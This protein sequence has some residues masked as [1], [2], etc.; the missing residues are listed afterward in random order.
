[1]DGYIAKPVTSN[2]IEAMIANILSKQRK[3]LG[4]PAQSAVVPSVIWDPLKA[5]EKMEGDEALLRE[6]IQIFLEE[7]PKQLDRLNE[8]IEGSDRDS[9]ERTAHSLK[10]E[11]KYL[12]LFDA[13]QQACEFERMGREGDW[14]LANERFRSFRS[15][16]R[17]VT[18]AMHRILQAPET[19][20]LQN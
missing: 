5:L 18:A 6:L 8:A 10:G 17:A 19:S 14:Q 15:E 16:I 2:E 4:R 9:M 12:G 3:P 11:L 7:S 13:A 1:M 20:S